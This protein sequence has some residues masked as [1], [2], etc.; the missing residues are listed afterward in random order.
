MAQLETNL[1]EL[2]KSLMRKDGEIEDLKNEL[3][4]KQNQIDKMFYEFEKQREK[5]ADL[6]KNFQHV[7]QQL[8]AERAKNLEAAMS[9]H[10]LPTDA[11]KPPI[12]AH[13]SKVY[14]FFQ[15]SKICS[16]FY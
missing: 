3:Q 13:N 1:T 12:S 8:E 6:E 11:A 14:F 15:S 5:Y 16:S 2:N 7:S 10:Q 9:H 4:F